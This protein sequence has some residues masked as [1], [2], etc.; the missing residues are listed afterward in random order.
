MKPRF[1]TLLK[2]WLLL[3]VLVTLPGLSAENWPSWRGPT[4]N[5]VAPGSDYPL[6]WSAEENIIWK[7]QLPGIGA[8]TPIIWED[9][10]FLTG[11]SGG[12]NS[13]LC[14]DRNGKKQWETT[15][16]NEKAAR[17]R[18]ASGSNHSPTTDGSH[19]FAYYKSG[20]FACLDMKGA[21][22]W[23]KNLQELY[24]KDTLWW[25]LGTSPVISANTWTRV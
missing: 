11:E 6:K 5:G 10:I 23:K 19:L 22:I 20:M 3:A 13:V 16:D 18:G 24:G 21:V 14:L 9:Q 2:V 12:M 17:N 1:T 7:Y 15:L 25:D 8:S 4:F